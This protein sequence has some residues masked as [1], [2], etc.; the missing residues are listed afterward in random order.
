VEAFTDTENPGNIHD[1]QYSHALRPD[2]L[3]TGAILAAAV[4]TIQSLE[5]RIAALEMTG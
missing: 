5:A 3:D 2:G 4:L 1:E